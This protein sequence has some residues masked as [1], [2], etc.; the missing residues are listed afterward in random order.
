MRQLFRYDPVL[1]WRFIADLQARVPHPG[2]GYL[3]RTNAHG[4]RTA[5]ELDRASDLDERAAQP[6]VLL[7][8]DSFTAADG[9]SDGRRY[10]DVAERLLGGVSVVN[11]AIPGTGPDQQFLTWRATCRPVPADLVVVGV[12][13]ENIRR[14]TSRYRWFA[15]GAGHE[16]LFAKPWF[17]LVEGVPEVRGTPP[18]PRPVD[19]AALRPA[20]RRYIAQRARRPWTRPLMAALTARPGFDRFEARRRILEPAQRLA[21]YQPVPEYDD[22]DHPGWRLL[23]AILSAWADEAGRLLVLPLPFHHHV[24][25]LADAAPYRRRFTELA[26]AHRSISLFDPLDALQRLDRVE[27]RQLYFAADGHPTPRWHRCVGEALAP[28][29]RAELAVARP[30]EV[31]AP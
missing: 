27:R 6:R 26:A 12:W 19:P 7:F 22:P 29:L 28:L 25:G 15:D 21:R 23:A 3:L 11:L 18:S 13:V 30:N 24:L 14:V 20:D 1:G 2:G 16:Q 31:V 10:G 4:F 5:H 8:G 17:E 9:V